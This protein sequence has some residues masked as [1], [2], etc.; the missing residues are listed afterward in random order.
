MDLAGVAAAT[1]ERGRRVGLLKLVQ[2]APIDYQMISADQSRKYGNGSEETTK[3]KLPTTI[4]TGNVK[5][6]TRV[7]PVAMIHQ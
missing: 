3:K 4:E 1:N 7:F 2:V 5:G 6:R